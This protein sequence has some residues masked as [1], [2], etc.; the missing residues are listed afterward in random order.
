MSEDT[1]N[2]VNKYEKM[3]NA[4]MTLRM[5]KFELKKSPLW[6]I[7]KISI[8]KRKKELVNA[9]D[10]MM[11]GSMMLN[12]VIDFQKAYKVNYQFLIAEFDKIMKEYNFFQKDTASECE[13]PDKFS[14]MKIIDCFNGEFF[15]YEIKIVGFMVYVIYNDHSNI[16]TIIPKNK[17][18]KEEKLIPE[19]VKYKVYYFIKNLIRNI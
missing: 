12:D 3:F 9:L 4:I 16:T 11:T 15:T 7:R 8:E 17:A 19:I 18:E 5:T 14:N 6:F 2:Q 10:T 1:R 13:N